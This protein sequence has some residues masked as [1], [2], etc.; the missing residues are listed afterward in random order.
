M[1]EV[2]PLQ[3]YVDELD[4]RDSFVQKPLTKHEAVYLLKCLDYFMIYVEKK[5]VQP[6]H[7]KLCALMCDVIFHLDDPDEE[8]K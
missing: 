7:D 1:S 4:A 8:V 5:V 6:I 2:N 3:K